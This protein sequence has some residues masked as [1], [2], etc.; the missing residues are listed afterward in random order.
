MITKASGHIVHELDGRPAVEICANLLG[1]PIDRLG[2]GM[3]WFSQFP[4][5]TN[6]VYGNSP[7]CVPEC[8]LPDGSIQFGP[9]M[10]NDQVLTLMR[11]SR[12]DIVLAGLTAYNK[13]VRQGGLKNLP[14]Q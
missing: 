3:L 5:G 10:K 4:F 1:I 9:L 14:L 6:D 2:D 7:L 13:A 8:V 12:E 11:A